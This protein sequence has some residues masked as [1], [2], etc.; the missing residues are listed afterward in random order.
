MEMEKRRVRFTL[1][2]VLL[3][4]LMGFTVILVLVSELLNE[5]IKG[6]AFEGAWMLLNSYDLALIYLWDAWEIIKSQLPLSRF[7]R[8]FTVVVMVILWWRVAYMITRMTDKK[9]KEIEKYRK[10]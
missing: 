3:G 1:E 10:K 9:Q 8:L 2:M 4:W 7:N 6:G 5:V